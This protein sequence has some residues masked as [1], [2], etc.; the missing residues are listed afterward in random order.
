MRGRWRSFL[1]THYEALPI[2]DRQWFVDAP[3]TYVEVDAKWYR[4]SE[5]DRATC[6]QQ[7][8]PLVVRMLDFAD[9]VISGGQ[10]RP[11][12]RVARQSPAAPQ[13]SR[14]VLTPAS[15]GPRAARPPLGS[16][17]GDPVMSGMFSQMI[18]EGNRRVEQAPTREQ[19]DLERAY[20]S[21]IAA[22]MLSN[23]SSMRHQSLMAV[24]NNLRA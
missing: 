24:V 23:M 9:E 7:W 16:A 5:D 6:A 21:Q 1:A 10:P 14:P 18:D 3:K 19:A 17:G 12:D 2:D 11:S 8:A 13:R 4:A 20:N 15:P 22:T